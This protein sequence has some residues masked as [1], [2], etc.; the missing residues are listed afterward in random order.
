MMPSFA[1]RVTVCG[2]TPKRMAT[3]RLFSRLLCAML[4]IAASPPL[5]AS[6][7]LQPRNAS[8]VLMRFHQFDARSEGSG[9]MG[10]EKLGHQP[11]PIGEGYRF[12]A[13]MG[14]QLGE[15]ALDMVADGGRGD[16]QFSGDCVR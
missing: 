15:H 16:T 3:S 1:Q 14:G 4:T 2:E 7:S 12:G 13:A 11:V 5:I 9:A 6:R 8:H 10:V